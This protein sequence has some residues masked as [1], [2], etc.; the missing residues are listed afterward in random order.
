[1]LQPSLS[2]LPSSSEFLNRW[3]GEI[4]PATRW[5]DQPCPFKNTDWRALEEGV[6]G[7]LTSYHGGKQGLTHWERGAFL[8]TLPDQTALRES[9]H[10]DAN[11]SLLGIL[12]QNQSIRIKWFTHLSL[13]IY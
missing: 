11:D 10:K 2:G 12:P 4:L 13:I 6:Q 8:A 1:M 5:L 9:K 7:A 3:Q